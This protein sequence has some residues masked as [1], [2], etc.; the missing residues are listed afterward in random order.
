MVDVLKIKLNGEFVEVRQDETGRY[1]LND[2]HKAA[3]SPQSKK[4]S[5]FLRFAGSRFKQDVVING[6]GR[7]A[8]THG[9]ENAFLEYVRFLS[10]DWSLRIGMAL[11]RDEYEVDL[12]PYED[13]SGKAYK[14]SSVY[15]L[16]NDFGL[17][18]IGISSNVSNR[19][20]AVQNSSGVPTRLLKEWV[21]DE[22][23]AD[24]F[25]VECLLHDHFY[26]L[27]T[28]GEWFDFS[29]ISQNPDDIV[30]RISIML[31]NS[32]FG[33]EATDLQSLFDSEE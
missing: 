7:N 32:L 10:K 24:A 3:G 13:V 19:V 26:R 16:Q 8:S 18:K 2:I 29:E 12:P 17:Y 31:K 4:V 15:L 22:L 30:E 21:K 14:G 33:R 1:C 25:T 5:E 9:Y 11:A 23:P 27:R 28:S 6:R 20:K